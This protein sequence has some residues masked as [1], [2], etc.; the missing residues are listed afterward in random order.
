MLFPNNTFTPKVLFG[1]SIFI[2]KCSLQRALSTKIECIRLKIAGTAWLF[3]DTDG[4]DRYN[5]Q[6]SCRDRIPEQPGEKKAAT[7]RG[8][9]AFFV[10]SP[11]TIIPFWISALIAADGDTL[12]NIQPNNHSVGELTP[13]TDSRQE[14][15][16]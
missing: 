2:R 4:R 6:S 15:P 9:V 12:T 11:L 7:P 1:K 14:S 8:V 10:S 16:E 3:A 13:F 5:M